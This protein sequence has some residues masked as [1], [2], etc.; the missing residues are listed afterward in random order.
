MTSPNVILSSDMPRRRLQVKGDLYRQG[1]YWK[2]R[3]RE[4]AVGTDGTLERPWSKPVWVGPCSGPGALTKRQAQR[5][6]WDNFLSRIDQNNPTPQ[7]LATL[8]E[9]VRLKFRPE[10]I[11]FLKKNTRITYES[12]LNNHILPILGLVKLRDINRDAVQQV[13][14]AMIGKELSPQTIHHARNVISA[15]FDLAEDCGWASGNP[16]RR[17]RMPRLERI[18]HPRAL[19]AEE[20]DRVL[21]HLA[22]PY[23]TMVDVCAST[24]LRMGELIALCWKHVNLSGNLVI[25]SSE[26]IP[27]YSIAVRENFTRGER[28]TPKTR[29]SWR[30]IP[31]TANVWVQLAMRFEASSPDAESPVFP[32]RSG[33]PMDSHNLSNRH[34]KPAAVKAGL[35][36]ASPHCL[37]HTMATTTDSVLTMAERMALL[38]HSSAQMTTRYTTTDV[39]MIRAKLEASEARQHRVN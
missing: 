1:N 22:E 29:R 24:G 2:L 17:V 36:W 8:E 6:A 16:A 32:N 30:I 3:W 31:M 11:Q 27:P 35:P 4:T 23:R 26:A 7:S 28:T 37:R 10:H 34:F 21:T 15:M 33:Q 18:R 9:F 39:E 19:S 20:I 14:S 38:G 5:I 12:L 13:I 25:L